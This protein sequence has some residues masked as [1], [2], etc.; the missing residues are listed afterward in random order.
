M[1]VKHH[2]IQVNNS[3]KMSIYKQYVNTYIEMDNIFIDKCDKLRQYHKELD[4][5]LFSYLDKIHSI[6]F[7]NSFLDDIDDETKC[8]LYKNIMRSTREIF[9]F[10]IKCQFNLV[11]K[12]KLF[13]MLF[14]SYFLACKNILEYDYS[15]F[16]PSIFE[17]IYYSQN[18][19]TSKQLLAMEMK[20]FENT[21]YF[22]ELKV[23]NRIFNRIKKVK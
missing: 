10:Q 2:I 21:N 4:I 9:Y 3:N 20:L 22:T 18:R 19:C 15:G 6:F 1:I 11:Q 16:I 5:Y 8:N 7:I 12:N 23:Y 17:L 14:A 13:G